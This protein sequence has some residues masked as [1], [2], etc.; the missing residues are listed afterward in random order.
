MLHRT[1]HRVMTFGYVAALGVIAY[2]I[3]RNAG[4][5]I[6]PRG[7]SEYSVPIA[8]ILFFVSGLAFQKLH[9]RLSSSVSTLAVHGVAALLGAVIGLVSTFG[10]LFLSLLWTLISGAREELVKPLNV[11]LVSTAIWMVAH[12]LASLPSLLRRR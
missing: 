5:W 1:L 10:V 3:D 8:A 2:Y 11:T 12:W 7:M 6:W 9:R 4:K